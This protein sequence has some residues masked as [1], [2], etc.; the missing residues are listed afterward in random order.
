[1]FDTGAFILTVIAAAAVL[2]FYVWVAGAVL[3]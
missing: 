2:A 1:M 3:T